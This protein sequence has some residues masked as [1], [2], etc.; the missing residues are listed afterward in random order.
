MSIRSRGNTVKLSIQSMS[1]VN[2]LGWQDIM[3]RYRQSAI[4]PFWITL[5]M[6]LQIATI[7]F[8]FSYIF[9]LPIQEYVPF[10]ATGVI[11]WTLISTTISEGCLCFVESEAIIKQLPIPL[12]VH[13]FR[14]V[15]RNTLILFHNILILPLI[16]IFLSQSVTPLMLLAIPGF[17]LLI[18]NL[19]WIAL[20][21]GIIS[22]RFRDFPNII[23]SLLQIA[24]YVTPVIWMPK[25]LSERV[26][27]MILDFNPFYH[28]IEI[29]R[30][31][32]LDS[33]PNPM[34]W[35]I[36]GVIG[37]IGWFATLFIASRY[38]DRV[39]FWV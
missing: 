27:F 5:S 14:A 15:W 32:I 4:G 29:I 3:Q 22:A 20:L 34:S 33:W 25:L 36:V 35:L 24:F 8:V 28:F 39:A 23:N 16:F 38:Q 21:L 1:V 17:L 26:E 2:V 31:P 13:V 37:V 30:S 11:I 6:V 10:L 7:G 19:V 12:F 9:H 18:F